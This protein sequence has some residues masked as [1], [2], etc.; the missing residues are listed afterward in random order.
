MYLSILVD[1]LI[2]ALTLTTYWSQ[3]PAL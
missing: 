3:Y 1:I 2:I